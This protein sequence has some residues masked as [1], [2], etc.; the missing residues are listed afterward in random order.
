M[1]YKQIRS[2]FGSC[3]RILWDSGPWPNWLHF[4]LVWWVPPGG[5]GGLGP[6]LRVILLKPTSIKH[7]Q[8]HTET[9]SHTQPHTATQQHAAT[10]SHTDPKMQTQTRRHR[11]TDTHRHPHRETQRNTE[12]HTQTHTHTQAHTA[13]ARMA[14][15]TD[16][17]VLTWARAPTH[18]AQGS[19]ITLRYEYPDE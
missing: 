19:N 2:H 8:K 14:A 7:T 15:T 12:T 3:S 4:K 5:V 18:G 1:F 11:H 13:H 17:Q 16:K 10:H 9:H 6:C